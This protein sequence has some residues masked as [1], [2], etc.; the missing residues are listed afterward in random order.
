MNKYIKKAVVQ[1]TASFLEERQRITFIP[2]TPTTNQSTSTKS[3]K[4]Y[5]VYG[6]KK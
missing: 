6:F 5:L 4:D 3:N 2:F 1:T